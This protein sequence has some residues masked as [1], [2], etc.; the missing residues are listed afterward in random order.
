[1]RR[2]HTPAEQLG[3][4]AVVPSTTA[5]A[6]AIAIRH[7]DLGFGLDDQHAGTVL[8]AGVDVEHVHRSFVLDR[9]LL[10]LDLRSPAKCVGNTD[11][12]FSLRTS[13]RTR[14][15]PFVAE[16]PAVG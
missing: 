13:E 5:E 9:H 6:D 3:I 2:L 11:N 16:A 10:H 1:M 4:A 14:Q 15:G 7:D 8:V 12:T